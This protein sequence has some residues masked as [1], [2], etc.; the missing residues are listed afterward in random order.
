MRSRLSRFQ[1]RAQR[2]RDFASVF[3]SIVRSVMAAPYFSWTRGSMS[4]YTM[5]ASRLNTMVSRAT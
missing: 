3:V 2:L 5:S 4:L 1:P